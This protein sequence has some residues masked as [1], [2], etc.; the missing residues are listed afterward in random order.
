MEVVSPSGETVDLSISIYADDVTKK[1]LSVEP[2]P[3]LLA[4]RSK[5][6]AKWLNDALSHDGYSMNEDKG[7][8]LV[9]SVGV[10]SKG[11]KREIFQNKKWEEGKP[12]TVMRVLGGQIDSVLG[13]GPELRHRFQAARIS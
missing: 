3:H 11:L 8:S 4:N 12:L 6:A 1:I 2:K 5:V 10:G 13:L 7:E 9:V